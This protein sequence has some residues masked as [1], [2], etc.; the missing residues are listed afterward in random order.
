MAELIYRDNYKLASGRALY[1][2]AN[3]HYGSVTKLAEFLNVKRQRVLQ[4]IN[5]GVPQ[6]Y[7]GLLGRKH[8]IPPAIFSYEDSLMLGEEYQYETFFTL[9]PVKKL[10]LQ[11]DIKYILAGHYVKNSKKFLAAVDANSIR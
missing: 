7:A 6:N 3:R 1:V 8:N 2:L 5:E 4:M 9:I 10:F 11:E